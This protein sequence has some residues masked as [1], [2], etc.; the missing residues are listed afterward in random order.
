MLALLIMV[1]QSS[2]TCGAVS[3]IAKRGRPLMLRTI[4]V[5]IGGRAACARTCSHTPVGVVC[6][7]LPT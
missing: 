3:D 4:P 1:E 7:H 2:A 6:D 5:A